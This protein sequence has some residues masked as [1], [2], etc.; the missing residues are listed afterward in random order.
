[1]NKTSIE[2][3]INPDGTPGFNWPIIT[4]CLHRCSKLYCYNT[5]KP[6]SPLN[7]FFKENRK[8]ETGEMHFALPEEGQWPYGFDPTYYPYRLEEPMARKKAATIFVANGGD[9]FGKWVPDEVINYVLT[10]IR[11][12]PQHTFI[13]LTKNFGRLYEFEFSDNCW[14]GFSETY[15]AEIWMEKIKAKTKFVSY[16]P[17]HSGYG[18]DWR[19]CGSGQKD[20]YR[21]IAMNEVSWIVIGAETG[22]RAELFRPKK[23]WVMTLVKSA[24]DRGIK[25][26][27]KNNLAPAVFDKSELIQELPGRVSANGSI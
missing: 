16:E 27:M 19:N 24:Q 7:R 22:S 23:D 1:M 4:G 11:E 9:L 20:G 6:S 2:Y 5:M 12:C 18:M 13:L 26:W 14:V 10:V 15:S 17:L 8:K 25:V 3:V 21:R